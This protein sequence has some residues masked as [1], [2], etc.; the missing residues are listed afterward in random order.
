MKM[1]S[2]KQMN[3]PNLFHVGDVANDV[4]KDFARQL[5]VE[6]EQLASEEGLGNVVDRLTAMGLAA[7]KKRDA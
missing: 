2:E 7:L 3:N 4:V 5:G 1:L 6:V